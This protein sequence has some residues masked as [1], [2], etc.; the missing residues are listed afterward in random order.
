MAKLVL[1]EAMTIVQLNWDHFYMLGFFSADGRANLSTWEGR[2]ELI[3]VVV[4][5]ASDYDLALSMWNAPLRHR[6]DLIAI[7]KGTD[8]QT[9]AQ[10]HGGLHAIGW[11]LPRPI[12]RDGV[13]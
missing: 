5:G 12:V 8:P 4:V 7:P 9:F 2:L 10:E 11:L 1:D 13:K 6:W 3:D